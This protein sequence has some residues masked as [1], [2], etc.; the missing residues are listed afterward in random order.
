MR[1]C[2]RCWGGEV[3]AR[4]TKRVLTEGTENTEFRRRLIGYGV[5]HRFRRLPQI[6]TG[7][8]EWN[9]EIGIGNWGRD[10][11]TCWWLLVVFVG[12]Y[13]ALGVGFRK[14]WAC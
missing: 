2:G 14:E 5:N 3:F 12:V 9:W 10:V 4:L 1:F 7:R 8:G 13:F 6:V 11:R